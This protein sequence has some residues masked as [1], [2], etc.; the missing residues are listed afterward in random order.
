MTSSSIRTAIVLA[1]GRGRRI[2]S[3]KAGL[4]FG[5]RPLLARVIATL[6]EVAADVIV[7]GAPGQVIDLPAGMA[8]RRVSDFEPDRGPLAALYS[9]LIEARGELAV[10]VGCDMPFLN[11]A[12][13]EAMFAM[14][15]GHDA[16]I[17]L[18]GGRRQP[19][20]A[21]Y[22][23][24]CAA[25]VRVLL[26]GGVERLGAVEDALSTRIL[27]EAEWRPYSPDGR[28]FLSINTPEDLAHAESI[29]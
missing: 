27:G 7:V 2:G 23:V 20:H 13:L 29:R 26:D 11:A 18:S 19:L 6:R 16:L 28:T 1:G 17:P 3:P 25:A 5:G 4:H 10:V 9:G 22:S 12:L 14:V 24:G 15:D 21:I 8:V